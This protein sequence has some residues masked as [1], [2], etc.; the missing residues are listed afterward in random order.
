M[1]Q[2][3]RENPSILA[4]T[5]SPP[6]VTSTGLIELMDISPDALLVVDQSG[7]I[8]HV[9]EQAAALFGFSPQDISGQRLEM[10]LPDR[11]RTLHN[12]H[13]EHYFKAPRTR[14]MGTGLLLYGLHKDGTEFPVD[15]SLPGTPGRH[16]QRRHYRA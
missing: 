6:R 9:N 5:T 4:A 15:I 12:S 10:L 7:T 14:S 13:R 8:L 1:M 2:Q 16:G 11:F 3:A